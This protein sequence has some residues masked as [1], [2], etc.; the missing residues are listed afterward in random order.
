M[1]IRRYENIAINNVTNG[2]NDIGEYTTTNTKWF[3]TR[4]LVADVANSLRI[5]ERYRVYSDLVGLTLNYTPNTKEIVDNQN[6]YSITWRG[7][8]WR[9]TDIRESNDRLTVNLLCYRNDPDTPV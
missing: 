7:F 9:I 1:G 3:D 8:D 5:S 4:A 6:L 2:V